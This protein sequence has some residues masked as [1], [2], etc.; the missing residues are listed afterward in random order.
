M[1]SG[2]TDDISTTADPLHTGQ[3]SGALRLT[4]S[5]IGIVGQQIGLAARGLVQVTIG[6]ARFTSAIPSDTSLV[7]AA[8]NTTFPAMLIAAEHLDTVVFATLFEHCALGTTTEHDL[9][10]L[11]LIAAIGRV[12]F[13][14]HVDFDFDAIPIDARTA[15]PTVGLRLDT[16]IFIE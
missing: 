4:R 11:H 13:D 15:L 10:V 14:E 2:A 9:I 1:L 3:N 16:R 7:L 8:G 5:A 12:G 6:K